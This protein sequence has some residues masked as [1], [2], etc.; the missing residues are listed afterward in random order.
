[1]ATRCLYGPG[2]KLHAP[3]KVGARETDMGNKTVKVADLLER[4]NRML[5]APGSTREGRVAVSVFIE[6]ILHETR[7]YAGFRYLDMDMGADGQ[8]TWGDDT[9][10]EYFA[11]KGIVRVVKCADDPGQ[12]VPI[13]GHVC[14]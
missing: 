4:A 12:C 6:S 2:S 5:A 13:G 10:R 8:W 1:M 11:A 9:R 14:K 7:N 3:S